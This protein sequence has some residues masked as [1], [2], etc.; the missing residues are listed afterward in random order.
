[1]AIITIVFLLA[2]L[3]HTSYA[4]AFACVLKDVQTFWYKLQNA[5]MRG[6][7]FK[8]SLPLTCAKENDPPHVLKALM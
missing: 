1:M 7:P 8:V 3:S 4:R 2:S 5:P 6:A